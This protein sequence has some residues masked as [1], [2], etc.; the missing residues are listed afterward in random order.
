MEMVELSPEWNVLKEL[1]LSF[2]CN[3]IVSVPKAAEEDMRGELLK[4]LKH[5]QGEFPTQSCRR[6]L[7]M[8]PAGYSGLSI[9]GKP[10]SLQP[11]WPYTPKPQHGMAGMK[12]KQLRIGGG[13]SSQELV[14]KWP[15]RATLAESGG[16]GRRGCTFRILKGH[17][18]PCRSMFRS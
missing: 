3:K 12:P 11:C 1:N 9:L 18:T 13:G 4:E 2:K 15:L 17:L 8:I 5:R 14:E 16:T 7:S 6:N 10:K